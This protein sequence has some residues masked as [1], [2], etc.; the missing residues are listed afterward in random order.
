MHWNYAKHGFHWNGQNEKI[1]RSKPNK[2]KASKV[3]PLRNV[4]QQRMEQHEQPIGGC[5]FRYTMATID[6]ARKLKSGTISQAAHFM[7]MRQGEPLIV[8]MDCLLQYALVY[9]NRFDGPLA[10]DYV[11][12]D[13]WLEAAK[14]IR[15]LLNGDGVIAM[16]HGVIAMQRGITTDSKDN[17]C[18]ESVF[19][20]AMEVAGF[21]ESDL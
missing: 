11:L 14:A 7:G 9:R 15:G 12:G 3:K 18:L 6:E 2:R 21:K 5:D 17:G 19:W 13:Y 10:Q 20:K 4:I 8:M 1:N 16:Q